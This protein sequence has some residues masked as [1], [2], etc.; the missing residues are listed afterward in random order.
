[1]PGTVLVGLGLRALKSAV[2]CIA[3]TSAHIG[4]SPITVGSPGR[5]VNPLVPSRSTTTLPCGSLSMI[6]AAV[7]ISVGPADIARASLA[8]RLSSASLVVATAVCPFTIDGKGI[9]DIKTMAI[10]TASEANTTLRGAMMYFLTSISG[11]PRRGILDLCVAAI[12]KQFC[13]RHVAAVIGREKHHGLR[14]VIGCPEAAER[15]GL[16][17]HALL[18]LGSGGSQQ[19]IQSW[20]VDVS[21]THGIHADAAIF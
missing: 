3:A 7:A 4:G 13:A 15:N 14:D 12:H 2:H 11:V 17:N 18:L 5:Q 19:A 10:A 1:M 8:F 9:T 21:R 16:G 6:L 20:R